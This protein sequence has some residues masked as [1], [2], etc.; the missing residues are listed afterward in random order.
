[1][2]LRFEGL[3]SESEE[4]ISTVLQSFHEATPELDLV[5]VAIDSDG[6][7]DAVDKQWARCGFEQPCPQI[8]GRSGG[9]A[10][11]SDDCS[12]AAIVLPF[13][14]QNGLTSHQT[15]A[16]F[17]ECAHVMLGVERFRDSGRTTDKIRCP[18]DNLAFGAV[19]EYRAQRIAYKLCRLARTDAD[20]Q[21]VRWTASS[22]RKSFELCDERLARLRDCE[23]WHSCSEDEQANVLVNIVRS[24]VNSVAYFLGGEGDVRSAV[25][26]LLENFPA[27]DEF[28]LVFTD[29]ERLL[30]P[31][32]SDVQSSAEQIRQSGKHLSK[33]WE[34]HGISCDGKGT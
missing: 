31:A 16:I 4:V 12:K 13:R 15:H 6:F 10:M 25:V 20:G 26:D 17:H 14:T 18:T 5:V 34:R 33:I 19:E 27:D 7:I 24:F 3:S 30:L 28:W 21:S 22:I 2:T 11:L 8:S 23:S 9:L 1:M 29:A 32:G